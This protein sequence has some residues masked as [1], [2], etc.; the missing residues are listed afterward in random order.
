MFC[1]SVIHSFVIQ[2]VFKEN[3]EDRLPLFSTQLKTINV[4]IWFCIHPTKSGYD[5][6]FVCSGRVLRRFLF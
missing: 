6:C 1:V 5:H 3:G 2:N 4:I